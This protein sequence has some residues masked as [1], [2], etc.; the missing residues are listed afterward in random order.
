MDKLD[1]AFEE[2]KIPVTSVPMVLYSSYRVTKDKKSFGKLI[3]I[4]NEFLSGYDDNEEYKQ[5]VMSGTGSSE[6]VR[7]RFDWWRS[8][9]RTA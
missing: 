9:I 8:K 5:F 2:I 1:A 7:G 4:I 3:E 6:N